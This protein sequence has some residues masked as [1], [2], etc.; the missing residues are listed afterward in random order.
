MGRYCTN[1]GSELN[2]NADVCLSCGQLVRT[3]DD[4]YDNRYNNSGKAL[5]TV[6]VIFGSL[7]FYPLIVIGS[8]VGLITSIIGLN[9]P[10]N[11]YR[12]RS[13]IGLGLSIGSLC[14]WFLILI[15]LV[16]FSTSYYTRF[17]Y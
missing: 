13:K 7:G 3:N 2:E 6:S 9:D 16:V 5:A 11:Q 12:S 1:C 17:Y 15:L 8:I 4:R 14:L 10:K